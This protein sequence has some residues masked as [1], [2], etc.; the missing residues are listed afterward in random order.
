MKSFVFIVPVIFIQLFITV[1][2]RAVDNKEVSLVYTFE[3]ELEKYK[4][5]RNKEWEVE[6]VEDEIDIPD[7]NIFKRM[8][9]EDDEEF[10]ANF[11]ELENGNYDEEIVDEIPNEFPHPDNRLLKRGSISSSEYFGS[12]LSSFER[13]IYD[14]LNNISN[15]STISTLK[16]ELKNLKSLKVKKS[17]LKKY[18]SR[19]VGAL[20]RDHPEYWWIKKYSMSYNSSSNYITNLK[21][22][23]TSSYSISSINSYKA[24]VKS[25]ATSIAKAAKKKSGT[26]NRLL[27]I[28][29]YLVKYIKYK[30]GSDYSYNIFGALLKNSCV[31][32]GYAE[33][34]TYL[35]RLVG[36]PTISVASS[37]HKW[38]YVYIKNWY[39]VDV[40]FDDPTV[41]GKVYAVGESKNLSHKFFLVGKNTKVNSKDTY[42][43]YSNRKLV[44]Y[45]E[46]TKAT[47][48]KFPTLSNTAYSA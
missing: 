16:I 6:N 44:T 31:C 45:L 13:R 5:K 40:T 43:T 12:Q 39:A 22:T 19:G 38:N 46:F 18:A 27:Y 7:D 1:Q 32:E 23:I 41:K 36:V 17:Y 29:D 14:T 8:A 24:K 33:S 11:K 42:S 47:G 20:V 35:S 4:G 3:S 34:F 30:D 28:H 9:F 37:S 10:E 2:S 15:K 48:F 25:K 26:Y 21:I